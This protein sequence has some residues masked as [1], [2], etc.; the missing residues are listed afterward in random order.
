[1][2]IAGGRIHY[3]H[4]TPPSRSAPVGMGA[5]E[6]VALTALRAA[7]LIRGCVPTIDGSDHKATVVAQMEVAAGRVRRVSDKADGA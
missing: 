6:F 3:D 2:S 4:P 7:Q 1:M 5:F